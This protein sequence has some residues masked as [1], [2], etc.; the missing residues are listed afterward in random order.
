LLL[1]CFFLANNNV[2]SIPD[3]SDSSD[4]DLLAY[5]PDNEISFDDPKI[6]LPGDFERLIL[7]KIN[8]V[9]KEN[10]TAGAESRP[11][12]VVLVVFVF[13]VI[14]VIVVVVF[15]VS[16]VAVIVV[17]VVII[18]L[19]LLLLLFLLLLFLLLSLLLLLLSVLLLLLLLL[20]LFFFSIG[21]KAT[22]TQRTLHVGLH[23]GRR[24]NEV[25]IEMTRNESD[26]SLLQFNGVQKLKLHA[27]VSYFSKC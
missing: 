14:V 21:D 5:L 22:V 25:K 18:V 26:D 3:N 19:L 23:N 27:H 20:L 2:F 10:W 8:T 6:S 24:V 1:F 16:V 7:K 11:F 12:V 17:V 9:N 15:V 4:W 13:V